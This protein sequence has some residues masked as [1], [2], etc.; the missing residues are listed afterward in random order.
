MSKGSSFFSL[1]SPIYKFSDRLLDMLALNF[2]WLFFSGLIPAV[3]LF[4]LFGLTR[5]TQF[6]PLV[7]LP[8]IF[9]MGAATTA[10]FSV[11]LKMVDDR[12]G[13]IFRPFIQAFKEN[14]K[15]GTILGIIL[16]V[17]A[18]AIRLDF[19]FYQAAKEL[20][21]STTG[22]LIVG[23]VAFV[24]AFLHLI[25]AFPLQARYENT[26]I[27]TLKNSFSIAIRYILRTIFLFLVLAGLILF[28]MWNNTFMFIAVL[29][30]PGCLFLTISS[31]AMRAFHLIED[32]NNSQEAE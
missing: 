21:Q 15:K 23:I 25:Y 22:F 11:T 5:M 31:W 17:V 30:G 4:F 13:Y 7:F 29:V 10:A 26:V 3:A 6:V 14:Y 18:C 2:L 12:E 24:L 16:I 9:G 27:N 1:E 32:A 8:V 28:F 19:S 20:H